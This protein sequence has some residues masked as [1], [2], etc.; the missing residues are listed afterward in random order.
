[1]IYFIQAGTNGPIKIGISRDP[2][3]RLASLQTGHHET[4]RLLAVMEGDDRDEAVMHRRFSCQRGE[5]FAPTVELRAFIESRGIPV[6]TQRL[7]ERRTQD[8]IAD[9]RYSQVRDLVKDGKSGNEVCKLVK[10]DRKVV[11]AL[12]RRAKAELGMR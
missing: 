2:V 12:V 6:D 5:W 9:R 7:Q 8:E 3:R 10:G 4:L 1:M 11:L